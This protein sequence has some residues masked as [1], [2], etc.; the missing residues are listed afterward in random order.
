M[1]SVKRLHD[2]VLSAGEPFISD[3][4]LVRDPLP[5]VLLT[6]GYLFFVKVIGPALMRNRQPF[7]LKTAMMLH[8]IFLVILNLF[9]CVGSGLLGW[10]HPES[11]TTCF[12]FG[13]KRPFDEALLT[14]VYY[15]S[16]YIDWIDTV[17]L[18]L[19]RKDR[20]VSL[21]HLYHHASMPLATW[22]FVK[23]SPGGH[24]SFSGFLNAFIHVVMY[25]YFF[26]ASLGPQMKPYLGWKKYLTQM[27]MIQFAIIF[28][29][30][31]QWLF[32]PCGHPMILTYILCANSFFL[33]ALFAN[34]Y[35]QTYKR[36]SRDDKKAN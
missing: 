7:E 17:F 29:H 33:F 10:F 35:I 18:V 23:L 26:L 14:Y 9:V 27:Q 34:F 3:W 20:H 2:R 30:S 36:E 15:I 24:V 28:V 6:A 12:L 31:A 25:S 21:L 13:R 4:P 1:D 16:K 11:Y 22:L 5:C 19:R 32:R 8:N